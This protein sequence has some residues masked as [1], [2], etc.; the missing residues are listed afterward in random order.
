M[1]EAGSN[2]NGKVKSAQLESC[3][4]VK[5]VSEI[6]SVSEGHVYM[7]VKTGHLKAID[8]SC[9]GKAYGTNSIRITI[10]SVAD[11]QRKR[12]IDPMKKYDGMDV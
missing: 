10:K 7:L 3:V 9:S 2:G 11:F 1:A 12:K 4:T 8:I 6:L 5:N